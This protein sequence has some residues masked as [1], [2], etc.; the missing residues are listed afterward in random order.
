[1]FTIIT[2]KT[3]LLSRQDIW[4]YDNQE[5]ELKGNN[6]FYHAFSVPKDKN[7][8]EL[9]KVYTTSIDLT[10]SLDNIKGG[11]KR[12]LRGYINKGSR[13]DF[14]HKILNISDSEIQEKILAEYDIFS[15]QKGLESIDKIWFVACCNSS[16]MMATQIFFENK[17]L[18]THIYLKDNER[19]RLQFSFHHVLTVNKYNG[20]F[21]SLAN[22]YLHWLDIIYFKEKGLNIYDFGGIP[23][24]SMASLREFK[25]SFG[26]IIEEQY[27]FIVP[28]GF[29]A[30]VYKL[31]KLLKK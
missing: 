28:N 3:P 31:K 11:C 14:Q 24:K 2:R 12:K 4:F 1:M 23:I 6:L 10:Q 13:T 25:L 7:V 27:S 29:Y 8:V 15:K 22:R 9:K 18:I 30:I 19:T 21:Q 20:Q 5:I 16:H 26:G 17:P